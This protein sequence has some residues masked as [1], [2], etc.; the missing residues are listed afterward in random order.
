MALSLILPTYNEAENLEA[1]CHALARVVRPGDEVIVVDDDSPDRT[2][3]KAEALRAAHPWLR[4]LRRVGRR[5]LSSAVMEG[6]MAA[7][8][9]VLAVMDADL[10]HDPQVLRRLVDAVS[11][12]TP[13][14]VASRYRDGGSTG[15]WAAERKFLSRAGTRLAQ[16]LLP[17]AVSDPMSGFFAVDAALFRSV[18]G[19]MHPRGF[20]ILLELL[21][22]LPRDTAVAEVPLQFH[23][24]LHGKSKMSAKVLVAFGWQLLTLAFRRLRRWSVAA[25]LVVAALLTMLWAPRAWSLRRLAVSDIRGDVAAA[26]QSAAEERGW[27]L[28]DLELYGLDGQSAIVIHRAHRRGE[29]GAQCLRISLADSAVTPCLAGDR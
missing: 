11:P 7:R 2:W 14:A 4:V 12:A 24:R 6:F 10:Q 3:E 25:L 21:S 13:V 19:R 16:A 18:S 8:G 5:G 9:S 1:L 17:V 23:A 28:S 26:L 20:K 27:L 15:S 22:A 29:D